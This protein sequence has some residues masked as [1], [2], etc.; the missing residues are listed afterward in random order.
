MLCSIDLQFLHSN[1]PIGSQVGLVLLGHLSS[2]YILVFLVTLPIPTLVTDLF[3]T[4]SEVRWF[5]S[6]TTEV[7][8]V[9]WETEVGIPT[10]RGAGNTN[11]YMTIF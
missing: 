5:L 1:L 3:G 6:P 11:N 8:G 4:R 10:L 9:V 7:S 2:K